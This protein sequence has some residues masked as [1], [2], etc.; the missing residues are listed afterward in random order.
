MK[1]TFL[2]FLFLIVYTSVAYAQLIANAGP[3]KGLCVNSDNP[4]Q[5]VLGAD[6]VALGGTPPYTYKWEA[7][8][9]IH[10]GSY[11]DEVTASYLLNDTTLA[12]PTMIHTAPF[13]DQVYFKLTV[14]DANNQIAIDSVLVRQ[15]T[16]MFTLDYW[17]FTI[18]KGQSIFLEWGAAA[19]SDRPPF[20]HYWHPTHGLTDSTSATFWAKPD[21]SIAYS[22]TVTDAFGCYVD[23]FRYQ[24]N[25]RPVGINDVE[26]LQASVFPN[27]AINRLDFK[28]DGQADQSRELSIYSLNGGKVL[29]QPVSAAEFTIDVSSLSPGEYLYRLTG[30]DNKVF[31]GLFV[32]N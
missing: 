25:V 4:N 12:N 31:S 27:P 26:L 32:K 13:S 3:D 30:K 11:Y 8:D 16:F 29:S 18:D 14:T 24:I 23:A 15:S 19:Y 17:E 5:P 10:I 9:T 20:Q 1:T 2:S 6:T 7:K 22:C 28:L 21:Y